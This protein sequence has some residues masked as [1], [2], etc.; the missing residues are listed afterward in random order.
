MGGTA[1][2]WCGADSNKHRIQ[3]AS[4]INGLFEFA[5]VLRGLEGGLSVRAIAYAVA[6]FCW[7]CRRT[8]ALSSGSSVFIRE[9]VVWW[10]AVA[11][12]ARPALQSFSDLHQ[13]PH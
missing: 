2:V 9:V 12:V 5:S 1:G 8:R 10:Q 13:Q 11:L 4:G 3:G 6:G 7:L